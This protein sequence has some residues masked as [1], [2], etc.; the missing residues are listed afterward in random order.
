MKTQTKNV[1]PV[2][3]LLVEDNDDDV[4]LTQEGFRATN[5]SINLNRVENGEQCMAFLR[6]EPPFENAP[7]VALVLLDINMPRM[8]GREVM[9]AINADESLRHLPV[10]VLTTSAAETDILQMYALRCSSYIVKPVMLEEFIQVITKLE[11]YWWGVVALP[12]GRNPK[13]PKTP[14]RLGALDMA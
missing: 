6:K 4:V 7:T 1:Q 13:G 14:L 5:L 12:N 10:V 8:D 2:E 9:A 3:L 11:E